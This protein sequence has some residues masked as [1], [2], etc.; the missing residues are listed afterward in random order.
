MIFTL[1]G[2]F[3]FSVVAPLDLEKL[4][5][6][7][8]GGSISFLQNTDGYFGVGQVI[9]DLDG[10][11]VDVLENFYLLRNFKEFAK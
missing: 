11:M 6:P 1:P 5:T 9:I 10:A 7:G 3:V 2:S 8:S 4:D